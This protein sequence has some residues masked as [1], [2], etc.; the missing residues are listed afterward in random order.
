MKDTRKMMNEEAKEGLQMR[1][2]DKN[3]E[4]TSKS[5]TQRSKVENPSNYKTR[6]KW[7]RKKQNPIKERK[8]ATDIT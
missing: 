3:P 5:R 6:P 7:K 4:L 8:R 1:L 2:N